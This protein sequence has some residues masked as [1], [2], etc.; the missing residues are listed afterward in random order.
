MRIE[1][2][3]EDSII[4]QAEHFIDETLDYKSLHPHFNCHGVI[5]C[6]GKGEFVK[7]IDYFFDLF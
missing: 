4:K 3:T 7:A 5:D 6:L 1:I 2:T